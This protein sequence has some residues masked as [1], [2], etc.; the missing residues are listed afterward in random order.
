MK[1]SH[2]DL[3]SSQSSAAEIMLESM[4]R[5]SD[6]LFQNKKFISAL[7]TMTEGRGKKI[8]FDKHFVIPWINY[9]LFY[10]SKDSV[11]GK[12]LNRLN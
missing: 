5:S 10:N 6:A 7:Q 11:V 1:A 4:K 2:F 9:F 12:S 3:V 8:I